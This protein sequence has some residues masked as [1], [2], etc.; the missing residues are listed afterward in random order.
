MA[1][2]QQQPTALQLEGRI[3]SDYSRWKEIFNDGCTD[4]TWK[5][6][7]N[8]DLVRNHILYDKRC[9]DEVLKD[10]HLAYP[11]SYFYP[12]P[13]KLPYD[14]MAKDR[15]LPCLRETFAKNKNISYNEAVKFDWGEVLNEAYS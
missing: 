3:L 7:V 5:D 6:G 9:C 4:P 10:N 13:V 8:I 12:N 14:F 2:K 15:Y 1:K 11:D